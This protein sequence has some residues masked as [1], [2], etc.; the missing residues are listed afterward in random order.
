MKNLPGRIASFVLEPM[1]SSGR[2]G[3]LKY[4]LLHVW[5]AWPLF[6]IVALS[7]KS[8]SLWV[9]NVLS[10]LVV[11]GLI[12]WWVATL[13][14]GVR[15]LHDIGCSGYWVLLVN[16]I[17]PLLAIWP[18]QRRTNRYGPPAP[19]RFAARQLTGAI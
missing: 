4:L 5:S 6:L 7:N 14:A 11:L 2:I 9:Q 1:I 16:L 15:R 12:Y 8:N 18:G 19:Q 3:R 13:T 10:A 17:W